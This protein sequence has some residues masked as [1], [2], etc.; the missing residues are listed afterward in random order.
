MPL[1]MLEKRVEELTV[2]R[3]RAGLRGCGE[4]LGLGG[5][6]PFRSSSEAGRKQVR[7]PVRQNRSP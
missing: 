4:W 3:L 5:K 2:E 1:L 7:Q 6:L